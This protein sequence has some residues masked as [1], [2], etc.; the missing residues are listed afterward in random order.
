MKKLYF[1]SLLAVFLLVGFGCQQTDEES[2][3]FYSDA[4]A[5]CKDVEKYISD[6]GIRD[7][8][9]FAEKEVGKNMTNARLMKKKQEV[10]QVEKTFVGSVPFLWT[11]D[12]CYLGSAEIIQYFQKKLEQ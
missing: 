9:V 4:C 7:K 10:C 12:G 2:I 3:F 11:K 1:F 8:V 5:H 6:N